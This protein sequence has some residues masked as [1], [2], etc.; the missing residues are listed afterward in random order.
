MQGSIKAPA[1]AAAATLEREDYILTNSMK[2][3][4]MHL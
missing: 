2:R 1:A 3:W 4:R